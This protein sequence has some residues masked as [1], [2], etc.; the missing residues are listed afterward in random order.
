MEGL[1]AQYF[2][3]LKESGLFAEGLSFVPAPIGAVVDKKSV[4][5]V[6]LGSNLGG[7]NQA[8]EL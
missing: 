2:I 6:G 4:G 1:S 3:W 8:E 7:R 5:R